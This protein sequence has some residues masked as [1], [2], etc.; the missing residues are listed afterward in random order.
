M[1][2]LVRANQPQLMTTA[3]HQYLT[4]EIITPNPHPPTP[5]DAPPIT[6]NP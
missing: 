1:G 3:V 2:S 5:R 4:F 6:T